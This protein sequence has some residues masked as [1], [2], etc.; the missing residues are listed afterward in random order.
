MCK[1]AMRKVF[2]VALKAVR[3]MLKALNQCKEA[4]TID[5]T[6]TPTTAARKRHLRCLSDDLHLVDG[7]PTAT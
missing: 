6:T 4:E 3:A 5:G 7:I 1:A 2:K